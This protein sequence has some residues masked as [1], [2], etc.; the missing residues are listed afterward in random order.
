MKYS[1]LSPTRPI[2][3]A[4]WTR[5]VL[6]SAMSISAIARPSMVAASRSPSNRIIRAQPLDLEYLR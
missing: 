6:T 1:S 5:T 4:G 3:M 2:P